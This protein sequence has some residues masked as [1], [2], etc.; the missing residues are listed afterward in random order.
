MKHSLLALT[1]LALA[2]AAAMAGNSF[3]GNEGRAATAEKAC[4]FHQSDCAPV[5]RRKTID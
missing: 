2:P 1:L 5:E 4:A 3:A